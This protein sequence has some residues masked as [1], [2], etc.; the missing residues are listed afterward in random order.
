MRLTSRRIS[1]PTAT[2]LVL[3]AVV[4]WSASLLTLGACVV[5]CGGSDV[6]PAAAPPRKPAPKGP[7]D[8]LSKKPLFA[9]SGHDVPIVSMSLAPDAHT[10]VTVG[11]D[12][13]TAK[14][15][16]LLGRK[17]KCDLRQAYPVTSVAFSPD[18]RLVATG[19]ASAKVGGDLSFSTHG[20]L[21]LFDAATC[22]TMIT[23]MTD[24]RLVDLVAW[25]ADGK[26][27]ACIEGGA[28]KVRVYDATK[29]VLFATFDDDAEVHTGLGF[30]PDGATLAVS[31]EDG[32]A[33]WDVAAGTQKKSIDGGR[34][35]IA[36]SRDGKWLA[37]DAESQLTFLTPEGEPAGASMMLDDKNVVLV[38][39]ADSKKLYGGRQALHV[40]SIPDAREQQTV[41]TAE[42]IDALSLSKDG[43]VL[44]V[45]EH[46]GTIE[47][48]TVE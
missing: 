47:I 12:E 14:V 25:S 38:F 8:R 44:A 31:S 36:W 4:A 21:T 24:A 3:R 22:K 40:W 32:L 37:A 28:R 9:F 2:V 16:D 35:S 45:G 6:K 39:A 41:R 30:S 46:D 34:A 1:S 20:Q 13:P 17:F 33:L 18:G 42:Q 29:A 7:K 5:G 43:S 11:A 15:W 19:S 48:F 27:L 23:P 10:L 26:R